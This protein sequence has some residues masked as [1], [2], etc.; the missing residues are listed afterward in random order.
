MHRDL[1]QQAR[2]LAR[3]DAHRPKQANLRRAIS[4]TYY[5]MFH[6]LVGQ[7]CR[8]LIG[9]Q[10]SKA[11]YRHVLARAFVHSDM[12]AACSS[13]WKAAQHRREK[14]LPNLPS[15]LENPREPVGA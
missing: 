12:K 15:S 6:F 2:T 7:S 5:A 13:F 14:V 11:A 1:L 10:Q 8:T 3:L 4:T 9:T